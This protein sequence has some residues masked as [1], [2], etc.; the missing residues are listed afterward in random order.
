MNDAISFLY[1]SVPGLE[2][3][4]GLIELGISVLAGAT[5]TISAIYSVGLYRYV[6]GTLP[7]GEQQ[8]A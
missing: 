1:L 3:C 5:T 4:N 6:R 2:I 7:G 8:A